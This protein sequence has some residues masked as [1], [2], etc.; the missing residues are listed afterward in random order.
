[1]TALRRGKDERS[2]AAMNMSDIKCTAKKLP[3]E[4]R[5]TAARRP[6]RRAARSDMAI[7]P[8]MTLGRVEVLVRDA[9]LSPEYF[10]SA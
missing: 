10:R 7:V 8:K 4:K 9:R 2:M 6:R 3:P 5:T 1:M